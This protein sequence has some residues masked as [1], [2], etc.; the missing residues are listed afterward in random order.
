MSC[1]QYCVTVTN[2]KLQQS[3]C[4]VLVEE[5]REGGIHVLLWQEKHMEHRDKSCAHLSPWCAIEARGYT[6]R[7]IY[8]LPDCWSCYWPPRHRFFVVSMC[9]KAKL[10]WF[11]TSQ[12]ATACLSC[13]PLELN[14]LN[15]YFIF[16]YMH[17]N[18]CHR[19]SAHLQLNI[20]L[21]LLCYYFIIVVIN[22][23]RWEETHACHYGLHLEGDVPSCGP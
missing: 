14:F 16:T 19:V 22:A 23:V 18:H 10:R 2:E 15:P 4:H 21:L 11:P 17:N 20:L 5:W 8:Y 9:L 13:S 6:V 3:D 7:D 1:K 12:V